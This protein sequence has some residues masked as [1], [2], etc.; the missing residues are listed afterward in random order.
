MSVGLA[1]VGGQEGREHEESDG[2][3]D[4]T[5]DEEEQ[6]PI[7]PVDPFRALAHAMHLLQHRSSPRFQAC[8]PPPP[9]PSS[10]T[11]T[12]AYNP[13]VRLLRTALGSGS[14]QLTT[15]RMRIQLPDS[16]TLC[17][18]SGDVIGAS[19]GALCDLEHSWSRSCGHH[20]VVGCRGAASDACAGLHGGTVSAADVG[21]AGPFAPCRRAPRLPA[22][23]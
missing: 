17:F 23:S 14:L 15:H 5:E 21:A 20:R 12:T 9:P 1:G 4:W 3:S 19:T 7:D 10:T 2:E 16:L 11:R 6:T 13:P 18:K 8:P 22:A